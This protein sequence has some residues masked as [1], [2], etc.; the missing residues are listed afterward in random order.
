MPVFLSEVV[1]LKDFWNLFFEF[2]LYPILGAAGFVMSFLWLRRGQ[3]GLLKSQFP[4]FLALGSTSY[5]FFRFGLL[6]TFNENQ[7]WADW[8]EESTEFIMIAMVV[9]FLVVFKNQLEL[10]STWLFRKIK[11]F[12]V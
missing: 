8:W 9:L 12:R 7:A 2:R 5:S 4:F 6:L 10:E 11:F 3:S 1:W